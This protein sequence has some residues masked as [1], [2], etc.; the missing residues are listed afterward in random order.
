[1]KRSYPQII[2]F[3]VTLS[4]QLERT[5]PVVIFL[6]SYIQDVEK[7]MTVLTNQRF[8]CYKQSPIISFELVTPASPWQLPLT[9]PLPLPPSSCHPPLLNDL[10]FSFCV[11]SSSATFSGTLPACNLYTQSRS[12]VSNTSS[13][14]FPANPAL[15]ITLT[16]LILHPP[17]HSLFSFCAESSSETFSGTFP[18]CNL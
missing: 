8:T 17:P 12:S 11:E 9:R 3:K 10:L 1:M 2:V 13:L 6:T 4:L 5:T 7:F 14:P 15:D 16:P 18:A